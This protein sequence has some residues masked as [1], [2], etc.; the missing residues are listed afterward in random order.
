MESIEYE[1][2]KITICEPRDKGHGLTPNLVG[3]LVEGWVLDG[4]GWCS[5]HSN[6]SAQLVDDPGAM[7]VYAKALFDKKT[8][9]VEDVGRLL[10]KDENGYYKNGHA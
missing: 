9:P 5:I 7:R 4:N 1:G 6:V 10:E 8:A 3:L 2:L